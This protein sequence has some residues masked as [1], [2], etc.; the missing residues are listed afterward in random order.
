M[1]DRI[2]KAADDAWMEMQNT[3]APKP[4][5]I[6][7]Y[8]RTLVEAEIAALR[9]RVK[10]LGQEIV[11]AHER[12]TAAEDAATERAAKKADRYSYYGQRIARDTAKA[13]AAAIREER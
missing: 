2:Q 4:P 1:E 6:A 5:I 8:M 3:V 12:L 7:K 13:I 9:A 10:E 11:R